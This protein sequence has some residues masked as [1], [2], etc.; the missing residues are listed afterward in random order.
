ME[1]IVSD[2]LGTDPKIQRLQNPFK[3]K[4]S[5]LLRTTPILWRIEMIAFDEQN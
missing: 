5:G 4:E 3:L 1:F 2:C